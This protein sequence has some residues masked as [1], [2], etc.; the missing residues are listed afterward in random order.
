M[1]RNICFI[2]CCIYRWLVH[3]SFT[4]KTGRTVAVNRA[5]LDELAL[6]QFK[7]K[8][9]PSTVIDALSAYCLNGWHIWHYYSPLICIFIVEP[10]MP[11]RVLRQFEWTA[12]VEFTR[13]YK[14]WLGEKTIIEFKYM[15]FSGE[16]CFW[17]GANWW[18]CC[19]WLWWMVS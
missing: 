7:W 5:I 19:C 15:E 17:T 11:N 14:C 3:H 8:P 18:M 9:Y 16:L 12:Q 1:F 6:S 4:E 13:E 2:F 10:H